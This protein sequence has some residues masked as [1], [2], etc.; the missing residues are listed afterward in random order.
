MITT[1]SV[2]S[3]PITAINKLLILKIVSQAY[4]TTKQKR[5]YPLNFYREFFFHIVLVIK[6]WAQRYYEFMSFLLR[7]TGTSKQK[8][9][10]ALTLSLSINGGPSVSRTQ[11]L[12]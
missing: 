2:K 11:H 12:C 3:I 10:K 8:R 6:Y 9:P 5:P 1:I 4:L 7:M